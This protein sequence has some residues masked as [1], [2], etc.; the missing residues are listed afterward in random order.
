MTH[1]LTIPAPKT[2][3]APFPI[4]TNLWINGKWVEA[5]GK[6]RVD[7]FD[8]STGK[9]ITDVADGEAADARAAVDAA[10]KAAAGWAATS[11]RQ[12]AEILRKCYDKIVENAEWLTYLISLE[13]GKPL[14]DAR[15]EVLY[16][17]EF[18]RWYAEEC[19]HV[20]GEL[21]TAPASGARIM[22]EYQPIGIA[23]LI[24]PWN[25]PAAMATRKIA[26]AL[27]A[28]CTVVLKPA[29]ETPLTAFAVAQIM[30][31]C[32]V[33]AGVVNVI[34]TAKADV[35]S[36]TVLHDPR[37][38]KL[39]FTGST[40]VGRTLL[41]E[42]A[43]QVI[44]CAME[45]GGNAPF[46]VCKDANLNDAL[47]GAMLAKMRNSGEACTAANRF[48]VHKDLYKDFTDGIV[49]RMSEIKLGEATDPASTL[50]PMINE[51]AVVKI[52]KLVDDAVTKGARLLLGGQRLNRPGFYYP[53][54]VLADVPDNADMMTDEIFG[55]VVSLQSFEDEDEA[56]RKAN[57][58]EYGL[59]AYI[60]TQ[61]IKRGFQ[62]CEKIE[63]GMIALNRGIMSDPAAPFGGVKQS[64]LGR[65]GSHHG[66]I[67][68]CE[69]KYISTIW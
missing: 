23:L 60:Y 1:T 3:P 36:K 58:T 17:A 63:S 11:P 30:H 18:Y 46:L 2:G 66:L 55:P 47:D 59:A 7:V 52:A 24:T 39:S 21:A 50:G 32:G 57:D 22:V 64:G 48:Y 67:E 10:D 25:Y 45:L 35:L 29:T 14:P 26:P 16:A 43:D 15:S 42:A 49:K 33:P 69:A 51:K 44:S 54:T 12:R 38:R 53:P 9:K 13:N 19:C 40:Q 34:T 41:H 62:I 65:E 31:D 27:A 37:V 6:K 4:P 68:F 61:D 8:P 20:L 28:G 5:A 56:I